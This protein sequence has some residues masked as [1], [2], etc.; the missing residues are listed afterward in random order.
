MCFLVRFQIYSFLLNKRKIFNDPVHGFIAVP[1][2]L[3]FKLIE[4]SSFQR[5]RHI[6]QLG[7][8]HYVY[9]GAL[10]TRFHHALGAYHLTLTA[11][12]TLR[13][14]GHIVSADEE[15][16]VLIAIL[17]HDMGHGP[18]SHTLESVLIPDYH[19]EKI[20]LEYMQYFSRTLDGPFD[21][22]ISIFE[23]TYPKPFL[24]QLV[25]S[26]LDMDRLDYLTRDSF[27]TGVSEGVVNY[28]RIIQ[29]LDVHQDEL[30]VEAKGIYSI[31]KFL[32][33]RRIMYWQV[34]LH[35]T[36]IAVE[37]MLVQAFKR[38]KY[39]YEHQNSNLEMPVSFSVFIKKQK[40]LEPTELL[41]KFGKID[42]TDMWY[43]IKLW[44]VADDRVLSF[45]CTAL[46]ERNLLKTKLQSHAFTK[47]E[48]ETVRKQI[49]NKMSI[50]YTAACSLVFDGVASNS[51]YDTEDTAIR[52]LN[53]TGDL[54]D[55]TEASDYLNKS[56][57]NNKTDKYFL[58][59][60]ADSINKVE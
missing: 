48:I 8:T 29:M 11:I 27:F 50:D 13:V 54:I 56:K 46:L 30:V 7:L 38:A 53:K 47:D 25:S 57:Q 23:K 21:I 52:I 17:L 45:L 12:N 16:G 55:I 4:Q 1:H 20:S 34:Y 36:V 44:S 35:K 32:I 19:H 51:A 2:P 33:A 43:A 3:I 15:L 28:N 14:K 41:E 58:C 18:F 49:M 9:P 10:H 59:Y 37:Q 40:T 60:P 24:C 5:L 22:A 31:E 26:Q 42:D 39:V 6:K